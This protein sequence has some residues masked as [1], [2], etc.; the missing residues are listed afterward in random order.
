MLKI[1]GERFVNN[2][3]QAWQET[4]DVSQYNDA[5]G[6]D[7]AWAKTQINSIDLSRDLS[8]SAKKNQI[9]DLGLRF[10]IV[11]EHTSLVAV[12]QKIDNP[13]PLN[14]VDQQIKT[15][16]PKGNTMSLPQTGTASDLYKNL[17]LLMLLL[18]SITWLIDGRHSRRANALNIK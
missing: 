2:K 16:L 9:T 10:H 5:L 12:E 3:V 11:T 18:A 14:S 17:G 1:S 6:I 7:V 8:P 4:I 13:D 15:H